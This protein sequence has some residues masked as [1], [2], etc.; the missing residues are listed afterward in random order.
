MTA[1][2][3]VPPTTRSGSSMP[4]RSCRAT[5]AAALASNARTSPVSRRAVTSRAAASPATTRPRSAARAAAT[6]KYMA[7]P[8]RNPAAHPA[9]TVAVA[10]ASDAQ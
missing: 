9:V 5:S 7:M 10:A 2:M 6:W 1:N 8:A 4:V 3:A